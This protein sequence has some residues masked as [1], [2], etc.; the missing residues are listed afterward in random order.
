MSFAI[1]HPTFVAGLTKYVFS[2]DVFVPDGSGMGFYL[3][4]SANDSQ[5]LSSWA[6][7]STKIHHCAFERERAVTL[8]K[9]GLEMLEH[10][11]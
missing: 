3:D 11:F 2:V 4:G 1:E 9:F 7:L 8:S 5:L 10:L 6:Y